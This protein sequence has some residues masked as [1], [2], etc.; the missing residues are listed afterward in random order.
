MTVRSLLAVVCITSMAFS[1]ASLAQG[2]QLEGPLEVFPLRDNLSMLVMEPA[3]N[4]L[5]S[6]GEDGVM[7]IDDQFAPM[8]PRIVAAVGELSDQPIRYLFNTLGHN[9]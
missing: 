9:Q 2:R 5:V 6:V 4:V 1:A 8:T 3:G 7:L